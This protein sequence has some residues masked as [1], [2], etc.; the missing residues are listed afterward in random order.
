[1]VFLIAELNV[2]TILD[3]S[4]YKSLNWSGPSHLFL[5]IHLFLVELQV[6]QLL[7]NIH[8]SQLKGAKNGT[9]TFMVGGKPEEFERAKS[10]LA[11]MGK[12]TGFSFY[13]YIY[14]ISLVHCGDVGSGQ[15]TKLCN[16]LLLASQ[17]IALA[18][19]MNLG[20]K[21]DHNTNFFYF[22]LLD[23]V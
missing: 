6:F 21:Y 4:Q 17:M 10:L 5:L 14:L 1:M 2:L 9:L 7:F 18:E 15:A 12:N 11:L 23:W 13:Y 16:N 3:Q 19:T 22:K 8:T 20:V